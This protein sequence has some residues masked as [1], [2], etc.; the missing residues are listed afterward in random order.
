MREKLVDNSTACSSSGITPACA[1]KTLIRLSNQPIS[2]GSP[3]R[4]REKRICKRSS[5]SHDGI[6][7]ACAGKTYPKISPLQRIEDHPR[8]C[9]K[10][11]KH[12]VL[13]LRNLGSPPRVREKLEI[14]MLLIKFSRITPACAGKTF[15]YLHHEYSV[16]D[17]PRVCGKNFSSTITSI[18]SSGSPPRVRE[19]RPHEERGSSMLGITPACAGKTG[20]LKPMISLM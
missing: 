1:G 9:G 6:T 13:A 20:S 18:Q 5:I 15:P 17:H 12:H 7:P 11:V 14:A 4:V 2:L 19:K 10:N 8:V 3:P 16:W